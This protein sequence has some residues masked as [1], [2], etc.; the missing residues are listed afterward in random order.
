M[1]FDA[2]LVARLQFAFTISFH[3]IFPAFTIGLSAWIATLLGISLFTGDRHYHDLARFWT[4]IFAV[5]FAM[6]VVS[7]IVITYQFG[8][9]WSR[10]SEY[11][12]NIVGPLIGYEV[13]TAFF[14]EASFLGIMLFG[15]NRV[16]PR[17]QFASAA[18]VAVG[19]CLSAFWIIAANSWMQA[20]AGHEIVG[21]QVI[22]ADWM[23][24]IFSPTMPLR[25]AHMV[26]AAYITTGFV[27]LAVGA[28]WWLRGRDMRSAETMMKM[29]LG[30][31]V[32]LTPLQLFVGDQHGLKTLEFQPAKIA[33]MEGHW[34]GD[35]PVPLVLFGIPNAAE[36]RNDYE[37]A[38]PNLSSLILTH[39]WD[40]RIQGLNDFAAE[41]RPPVIFPF[42]GFR[43]MV[44]LGLLMIAISFLGVIKWRLGSLFR[45]DLFMRA[46]SLSWP[47][48]FLAVIAGWITTETGRQPFVVTGLLRTV[49]AT[50][51]VA[52][53]N[54]Y[55]SFVLFLAVYAVI[56]S[57]GIYYINRLLEVGPTPPE[58]HDAEEHG[59]PN[60]PISAA[61][62]AG[63]EA[64]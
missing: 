1:D 38:I 32:V 7:G 44:G 10:F 4:R 20:P 6:G 64:I 49:D 46:V 15:W 11:A 9:N 22:A 34:N 12:G 3:I 19:T 41:D 59:I 52:G 50:S 31:L 16:S 36:G 40:G 33:A 30:L 37:L 2:T 23:A 27:V 14:L 54:V 56:F 28:R 57:S 47:I 62:D 25:L 8:T 48:G 43:V 60:R 29:A 55:V 21:D 53:G 5:S 45:A 35:E 24:V 39:S 63:R 58:T 51:P 42:V 17:L 13:M 26:L 61:H 18:I